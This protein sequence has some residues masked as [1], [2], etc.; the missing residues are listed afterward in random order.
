MLMAQP[1]VDNATPN[2]MMNEK[3]PNIRS[4]KRTATAGAEIIS[5]GV[6]TVI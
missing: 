5:L 6:K 4:A 1:N 2:G 3:G